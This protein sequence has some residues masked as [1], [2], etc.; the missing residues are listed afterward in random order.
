MSKQDYEQLCLIECS[1]CSSAPELFPRKNQLV[2]N[3][4]A[5]FVSHFKILNV[6]GFSCAYFFVQFYRRFFSSCC[7]FLPHPCGQW[8]F[9]VCCMP[10]SQTNS[11]MN[12]ATKKQV[13]HD[14][15]CIQLQ[16]EQFGDD[17]NNNFVHSRALIIGIGRNTRSIHCNMHDYRQLQQ[18]KRLK[19]WC[20]IIYCDA[21]GI[22]YSMANSAMRT[23]STESGIA[24]IWF[25][26]WP[27]WRWPIWQAC[28]C[29]SRRTTNWGLSAP[30]SAIVVLFDIPTRPPRPHLSA[31]F[32]GQV[33][34]TRCAPSARI[35]LTASHIQWTH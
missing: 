14:I 12:K 8:T 25:H 31:F 3:R 7:R 1:W 22:H 32:C 5:K 6:V 30:P 17:K 33:I 26:G 2:A 16:F 21:L 23:V 13:L 11:N 20:E 4:H 35:S 19:K 9:F 18:A 15:K 28:E 10:T 34:D 27:K 24:V 29:H